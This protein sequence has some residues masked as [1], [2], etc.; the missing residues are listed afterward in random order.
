MHVRNEDGKTAVDYAKNNK[1]IYRTDIYQKMHEITLMK[2]F[3]SDNFWKTAIVADVESALESGLDI[4]AKNDNRETAL[5][6]ASKYNSNTEV[7]ET[8]IEHGADVHAHIGNG[9]TA[10]WFASRYNPNVA[11]IETL[12][13]H[14]ADVNASDIIWHDVGSVYKT[15]DNLRLRHTEGTE[16][17]AILTLIRGT[18]VSV[19]EIGTLSKIDGLIAYWLKV[20]V[21][22]K[23]T[24]IDGNTVAKGKTGW[25]FGGY[26]NMDKE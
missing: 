17:D 10:L 9:A 21:A 22:E 6:L 2:I 16:G 13:Q 24:D 19:Q 11:I 1:A 20:E 26:V 5:M 14:G 12:L 4:N 3:L 15:N 23:T 7:I 8:L 18:S 25:L